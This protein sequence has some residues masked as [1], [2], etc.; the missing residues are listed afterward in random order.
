[1]EDRELRD[2]LIALERDVIN[3][4]QNLVDFKTNDFAELKKEVNDMRSEL[5]DKIDVLLEKVSSINMTM[6]KWMGAGGVLIFVVQFALDK[7]V[8]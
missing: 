6:A 8:K 3:D 7:L 1:M 2:R 5:N 4:K